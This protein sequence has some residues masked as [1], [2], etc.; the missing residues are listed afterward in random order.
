MNV[1]LRVDTSGNEHQK[2]TCYAPQELDR[3]LIRKKN[4]G[5]WRG[6]RGRSDNGVG[7]PLDSA[8]PLTT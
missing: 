7:W 4:N 5:G 2:I 3:N 8:L 6:S 1:L